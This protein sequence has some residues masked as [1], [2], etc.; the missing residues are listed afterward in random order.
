MGG[1]LE[2]IKK[3]LGAGN[4]F[5]HPTKKII[6]YRIPAIKDLAI[7]LAHLDKYPLM[8]QKRADYE[9]FKAGYNLVLNKQ[10]LIIDGL[11]QIV[12][13]KTSMNLGLSDGLPAAFA[14]VTPEIRPIVENKTIADPQ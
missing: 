3:L 7:L 14:N 11:V 1:A 8:T 6:H 13:L 5:K 9:L 4:I 10:H 2:S 12:A